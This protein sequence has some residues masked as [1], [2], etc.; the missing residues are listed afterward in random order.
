MKRLHETKKQIDSIFNSRLCTI[1]LSILSAILIWFVISVNVYPTTPKTFYNIPLVVDLEGTIAEANGLSVVTS[2]VQ[3]VSVQ[4]VGNRSQVG[5]L[6]EED[7]TAYAEVQNIGSTGRYTLDIEVRANNNV[8]FEVNTIT[9]AHVSVEL[10]RIETRSFE[11]QPSIPNISV[12]AGHTMDEI[13]CEPS[14]IE[15]SGPSAQ[16]DEIA[17]VVVTS[18]KTAEIDSSYTLYGSDITLYTAAGSILDAEGLEIPASNFKIDIPIL[19][20]KELQLTYNLLNGPKEFD[21]EWLMERLLLS[22]ESIT[23]A[24]TNASL[25]EQETWDL[26]YIKLEEIDLGYST[27]FAIAEIDGYINQSGIQQVNLTLDD[28]GLSKRD[29]T[30]SSENILIVNPPS[31]YEFEMIT[32]SLTVSVIGPTEVL[33]EMSAKDII[34]TVDLLD[35]DPSQSVSFTHDVTFSFTDKR[36]WAFG[37]YKVALNRLEIEP[38]TTEPTTTETEAY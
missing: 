32:K 22:D 11:V 38:E 19:T 15:I 25:A 33:E 13:T 17:S 31:T 26:G 3:T 1:I 34:V 4:I 7:L 29:F 14:T 27:T 23:Y 6:T 12:T 9:P 10:D 21:K 16:L 2:D 8:K 18:D 20:Q 24:S 30:L 35:Y 5:I 37:S 36:V 28:E